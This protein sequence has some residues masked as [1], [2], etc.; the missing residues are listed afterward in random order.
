MSGNHDQP[1]NLDNKFILGFL[2]NSG[3]MIFEFIVGFFIGSLALISDAA[4]NLTD[5]TTLVISFLAN[6]IGQRKADQSKTYGYG[7]ATILAAFFNGVVLIA[8]AG[9]IFYEAYLRFLHPS[10]VDGLYVMLVAGFGIVINAAVALLFLG[11]RDDPNVRSAFLNMAFDAVASVGALIG[12]LI[13]VLTHQTWVDP[14][15]GVAI[16][17]MLLYG[18]F[19]IVRDAASMLLEGVPKGVDV[20]QVKAAIASVKGVNDVDDL[21]IWAISS[22]QSALSCHIVIDECDLVTS[23]NLVAHI[24]KQLKRQFNIQHATI[25]A[26]MMR[27]ESEEAIA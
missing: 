8:I 7:R 10:A 23:S 17:V 26:E 9:Y 6:R 16:G 19:S 27:C 14:L 5:S 11:D 22:Q 12:G 25:E 18:A 21:H 24:K 1:K 2:L 20:T 3:F 13:I 15:I 4:H